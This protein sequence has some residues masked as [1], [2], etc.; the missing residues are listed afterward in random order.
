MHRIF[1]SEINWLFFP[2]NRTQQ[3]R[4]S[5]LSSLETSEASRTKQTT[6]R[7][8]LLIN[9]YITQSLSVCN[10][11]VLDAMWHKTSIPQAHRSG[12][13]FI[14]NDTSSTR[15]RALVTEWH[16]YIRSSHDLYVYDKHRML[17][18]TS[19]V[20]AHCSTFPDLFN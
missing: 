4:L 12:Y 20:I 3:E 16:K 17:G 7:L 2:L 18:S 5:I 6:A 10:R 11:R 19:I 13:L 14:V 15:E 8:V 9:C 1:L